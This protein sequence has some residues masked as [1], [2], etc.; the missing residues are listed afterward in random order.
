MSGGSFYRTFRPSQICERCGESFETYSAVASHRDSA[1]CRMRR[2]AREM[3]ARGWVAIKSSDAAEVLKCSYVPCEELPVE[4]VEGGL[5]R[6][7]T[8]PGGVRGSNRVHKTELLTGV[9]A[10]PWAVQVAQVYGATR[11]VRIAA[12]NR[13]AE[14][15]LAIDALMAA[16]QLS[17]PDALE[18]FAM[19]GEDHAEDT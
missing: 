16:L 18:A 3:A 1:R 8:T 10:P 15:P 7:R 13:V 11:E 14:D 19:R 2:I 6:K 17:G 12:L 9:W 4:L 5:D